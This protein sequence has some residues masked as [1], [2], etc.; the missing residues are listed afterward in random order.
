M[1]AAPPAP[2]TSARR[3]AT[4]SPTTPDRAAARRPGRAA[5]AIRKTPAASVGETTVVRPPEVDSASS[6]PTATRARTS[7][8][9][10]FRFSRPTRS[11][12]S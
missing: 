3:P 4:G 8:R 1:T 6:L 7:F 2:A 10:A 11:I 12:W 9:A 5:P